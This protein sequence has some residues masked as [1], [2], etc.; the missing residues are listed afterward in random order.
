MPRSARVRAADVLKTTEI[1]GG[2][3]E[4]GA[5]RSAWPDHL[6]RGL[7]RLLGAQVIIAAELS[8]LGTGEPNES[9]GLFRAGWPDE[10]AE[11]RWRDYA[12][13]IPVEQKP[14]FP[15][16]TK[17]FGRERERG[18]TLT[19]DAIWGGPA[20]WERSRA[21][22]GVHRACGID[23]YVFSVR[24]APLAGTV[25]TLWVHRALGDAPF[26][27]RERRLLSLVHDQLAGLIGGALASGGEPDVDD[28]PP[29]AGQVLRLLLRGLS[30]KEAAAEL[31]I[32]KATVHEH[33]TRLHR[34]FGV[35]SR[36]ELLARFIG[37]CP[38][39]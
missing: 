2:C 20:V 39:R 16:V 19:R 22:N 9:V 12:T 18:V 35:S 25:S 34:H 6:M 4:R 27:P 37:R 29:R 31:G 33:A 7:R 15:V 32:G 10:A 11:R 36:A 5:A 8:G 13:E 38:P 21:F 14:E 30:E 28:L 1:M 23:D 26:T 17:M 3:L 24:Q